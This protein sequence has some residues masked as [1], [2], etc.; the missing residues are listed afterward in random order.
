MLQ[1]ATNVMHH[2]KDAIVDE[3]TVLLEIFEEQPIL[4]H[5]LNCREPGTYKSERIIR[6]RTCTHTRR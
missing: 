2:R 6:I 1:V 4:A 3:L 5:D